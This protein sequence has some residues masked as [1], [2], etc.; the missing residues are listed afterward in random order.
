MK[1]LMILLLLAVIGLWWMSRENRDL[2]RGLGSANLL[3]T[4]QEKD[5]SHARDQL[6]ALSENTRRNELAQLALRQQLVAAQQL[7]QRRNQ[8]MTRLL[9][10]NETLR[11]WYQSLLPDDIARLHARPGF[12]N[13]TDYLRWLSESGELPHTGQ[14][15]QN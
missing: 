11:R 6:S 10:E 7:S 5:L 2:S 8:R 14:P 12:D 4:L 13:P 3:I 9:N 15:A 1:T